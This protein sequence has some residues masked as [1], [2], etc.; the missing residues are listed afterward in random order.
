MQLIHNRTLFAY[1][2][3]NNGLIFNLLALL[4]MSQSPRSFY[5]IMSK[6]SMQVK[7]NL[8]LQCISNANAVDANG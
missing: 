1:N 2:F 6:Q 8:C 7:E 4:E 5:A 3:L